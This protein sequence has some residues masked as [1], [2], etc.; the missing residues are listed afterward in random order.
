MPLF[1]K[2]T[3]TIFFIL[4]EAIFGWHGI[5]QSLVPLIQIKNLVNFL[6]LKCYGL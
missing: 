5:I 1:E 2:L 4:Y 3:F 6:E